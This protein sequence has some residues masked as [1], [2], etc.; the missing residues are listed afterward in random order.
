[1]HVFHFILAD[2]QVNIA[3]IIGAGVGGIVLISG[4]LLSATY[5]AKHIRYL[6]TLIAILC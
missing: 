1:M 2:H 5:L 6:S 3:I 4:A